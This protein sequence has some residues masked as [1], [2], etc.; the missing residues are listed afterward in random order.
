MTAAASPRDEL[1]LAIERHATSKLADETLVR[2]ATLGFRGEALP[3]I[4]AAAKLTLISRPGGQDSA[5][6]ITVAGG[7]VAAVAPAAGRAGTRAIVE[8]LFYATPARRKFLRTPRAEADAAERAVW[9]L[10][11]AAPACRLP[12]GLG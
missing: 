2:I 7:E 8:D 1:A 6:R 9:R 3:S 11:L 12:P 10:A 4:G 5:Y